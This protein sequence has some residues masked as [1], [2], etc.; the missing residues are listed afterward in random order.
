MF[1][2]THSIIKRYLHSREEILW[3]GHPVTTQSD[4]PLLSILWLLR[5][6]GFAFI[7]Y[8]LYVLVVNFILSH[9]EG[10]LILAPAETWNKIVFGVIGALFFFIFRYILSR[11]VKKDTEQTYYAITNQRAFIVNHNSRTIVKEWGAGDIQKVSVKK[12]GE[13]SGDILFAEEAQ[14]LGEIEDGSARVPLMWVGFEDIDDLA[15]ATE[16]LKTWKKMQRESNEF[17]NERLK[18]R[19][20]LPNDWT[21]YSYMIE[22]EHRDNLFFSILS[23]ELIGEDRLL[24]SVKIGGDWDT[25]VLTKRASEIVSSDFGR[26]YY[27][28]ILVEA[29]IRDEAPISGETRYTNSDKVNLEGFTRDPNRFFNTLKKTIMICEFNNLCTLD[30]KTNTYK[31]RI[32]NSAGK[33]ELNAMHSFGMTGSL[34]IMGQGYKFKQIYSYEKLN[35]KNYLHLRY[36]FFCTDKDKEKFYK[37]SHGVLDKIVRSARAFTPQLEKEEAEAVKKV[38]EKAGKK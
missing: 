21:A 12:R 20:I 16:A 23:A 27:L 8:A 36:T 14:T 19:I 35:D 30:P 11:S 15:N 9:P 10:G 29:A 33:V 37:E 25:L 1:G 2:D 31:V 7:F 18:F 13:S 34:N 17:K 24:K 3:C 28:V 4:K 6:I 22:R 38:E 32:N 26:L 5:I